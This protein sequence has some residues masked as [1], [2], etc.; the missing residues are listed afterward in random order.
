MWPTPHARDRLTAGVDGARRAGADALDAADT[1]IRANVRPAGLED[2][3]QSEEA[4][5]S[6]RGSFGRQAASDATSDHA[7]AP[8][9]SRQN[10]KRTGL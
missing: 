3:S 5:V 2:V 10:R 7:P 1:A 4:H 6:V 9:A 8:Q